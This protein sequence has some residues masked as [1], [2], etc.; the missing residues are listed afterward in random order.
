[1]Y[2]YLTSYETTSTQPIGADCNQIGPVYPRMDGPDDEREVLM[3]MPLWWGKINKRVFNPSALKNGKWKV[4]THVG[5]S[6]GRI[7]RT[8]LEAY[9]VDGTFVFILVYGSRSDWVQNILHEGS[10]S[11][12]ADDELIELASPRL[13]SAKEAWSLLDGLAKPPPGFLNVNEFLQMDIASRSRSRSA[14]A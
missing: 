2:E 11:L 10:G 6:S 9:E 8:P 13:I 1:M 3:P 12:Q 7:Y 5:R 4:L 14:N